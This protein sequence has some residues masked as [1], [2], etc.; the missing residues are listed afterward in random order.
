MAKQT[1]NEALRNFRQQLAAGNQSPG[2]M[3]TDPGTVEEL[4]GG[5]LMSLQNFV[6]GEVVEGVIQTVKRRNFSGGKGGGS[7]PKLVLAIDSDER[8]V[9]VN[10]TNATVLAK[11]LG[12]DFA[13][14]PGNKIKIYVG[15]LSGQAG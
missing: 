2:P 10:K 7:S 11:Y 12:Q 5:R 3:I 8:G 14:W 4:Y 6:D 15:D 1:A 9:P 13:K